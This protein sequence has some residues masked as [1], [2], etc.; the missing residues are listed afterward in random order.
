MPTL[1][2]VPF[3]T[4]WWRMI[5]SATG[6]ALPVL[7]RTTVVWPA[8]KSDWLLNWHS[9]QLAIDGVSSLPWIVNLVKESTAATA[10]LPDRGAGDE[11]ELSDC[12]TIE[13]ELIVPA[14]FRAIACKV[15]G[16]L[17]AREVSQETK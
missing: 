5:S 16:P 12:T 6:V 2:I 10:L 3:K 14:E 13:V 8:I 11:P 1:V 15:C 17:L 7:K 4:P 9:E